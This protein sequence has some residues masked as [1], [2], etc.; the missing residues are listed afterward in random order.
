MA[1]QMIAHQELESTLPIASVDQWTKDLEM[2]EADPLKPN[3][4]EITVTGP[5][6]ANV[7]R[8]LVEDEAKDLAHH[9]KCTMHVYNCRQYMPP[10]IIVGTYN[11]M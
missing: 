4:F 1:E 3:P 9:Q 8:Q 7:W 10:T 2:W 11:W 6:L 5:T